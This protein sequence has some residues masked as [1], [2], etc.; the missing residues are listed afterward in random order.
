MGIGC[1]CSQNSTVTR[2]I[3]NTEID[4]YSALPFNRIMVTIVP[5]QLATSVYT[6]CVCECVSVC[7]CV[8]ECV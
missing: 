3:I 6:V 7:V 2:T 8:C 1:I 5:L 4:I